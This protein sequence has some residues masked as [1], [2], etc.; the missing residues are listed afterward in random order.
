MSPVSPQLKGLLAKL[1]SLYEM[2]MYKYLSCFRINQYLIN[3]SLHNKLHCADKFPLYGNEF[4]MQWERKK[5][6][7]KEERECKECDIYLE[8]EAVLIHL[9]IIL[10]YLEILPR[11][12]QNLSIFYRILSLEHFLIS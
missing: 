2:L 3:Y 1:L 10:L 9:W 4:H 5:K 7:K 6:R 8:Q 12:S 11:I